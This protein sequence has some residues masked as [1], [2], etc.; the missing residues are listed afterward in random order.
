MSNAN[1]AARPRNSLDLDHQLL[2]GTSCLAY[3]RLSFFLSS[4]SP[5][6]KLSADLQFTDVMGII[7]LLAD[8]LLANGKARLSFLN[9]W[10]YRKSS[11][12]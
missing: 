1:I 8:T 12:K 6:L 5:I 10:L 7:M 2:A 3:V 9:S 4:A 11:R